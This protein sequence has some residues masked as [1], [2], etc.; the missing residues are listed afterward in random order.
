MPSTPGAASRRSALKPSRSNSTVTWWR[1]AVNRTSL[2]LIATRRTRSSPRCT[3]VPALCPE[4]AGLPVFPLASPLSSTDSAAA[5]AALF[6][7][8]AGTTGLC[9]C[10]PSFISGLGPQPSPSGLSP[11]HGE[12]RRWALPVLAHEAS[13]HALVLGPRGALW[14][15][16]YSATSDVAFRLGLRRRHPVRIDFAAQS[17]G[18]H[19]PLSTLRL[20]PHECQ[21][22]TRGHLGR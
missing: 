4:R 5:S 1:S 2:S 15:L 19:V 12:R 22:M 21:R 6:A 9:D 20:H 3:R 10:P 16:A 8:F 13:V 14:Q 18:L 17:P 11:D 7:G